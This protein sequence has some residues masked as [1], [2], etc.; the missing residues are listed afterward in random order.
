MADA[1]K[2]SL[3]PTLQPTSLPAAMRNAPIFRAIGYGSN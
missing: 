3:N 2:K 1:L